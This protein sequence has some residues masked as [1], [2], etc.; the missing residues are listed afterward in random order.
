MGR[1]TKKVEKNRSGLNEPDRPGVGNY[2]L[3]GHMW[4]TAAFSVAR[5]SIQKKSSNLR[6]P[7]T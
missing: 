7:P 6:F 5:G 1:G 3:P 4:P 2:R